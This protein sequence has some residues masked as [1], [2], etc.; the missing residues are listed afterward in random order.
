MQHIGIIKMKNLARSFFGINA[1]IEKT[2]V[3]AEY[4]KHAHASLKYREQIP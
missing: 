3:F 4:E 1:D 2:K